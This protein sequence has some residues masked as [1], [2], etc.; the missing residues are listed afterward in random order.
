MTGPEY[1]DVL[2]EF[3]NVLVRY[4][5]HGYHC[6]RLVDDEIAY[7]MAH[8][9]QPPNGAVLAERIGRLQESG[10][11]ERAVAERLASENQAGSA[12][13]AGRIWFCFFP[14]YLAGESGIE[15]L[16][17]HWG[18]EAL[19]NS[20]DRDPIV[21]PILRS[22][23]TPFLVEADVPI[24]GLPGPGSVEMKLAKNFLIGRGSPTNEPVR[25]EDRATQPIPA[26]KIKRIIRFPEHD[27]VT[28]TKCDEWETPL[29]C[30]PTR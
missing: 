6:T 1:D 30:S 12:N 15:A 23:G 20:H 7:I 26:S 27:F 16:L 19:Y 10:L 28:L 24:A 8:G 29:A 9:M 2:R 22:P 11:V 14:P 25:H 13:R 17:R 21:G 3:R 5:L 4:D 18:G